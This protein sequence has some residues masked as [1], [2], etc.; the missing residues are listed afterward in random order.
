MGFAKDM[1]DGEWSLDDIPESWH[2]LSRKP[3]VGSSPTA[4]TAKVHSIAGTIQV[5]YPMTHR[6]FL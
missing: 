6:N 4:F 3:L 5:Q 2:R 1:A